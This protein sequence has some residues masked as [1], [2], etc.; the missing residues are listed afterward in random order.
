MPG[1][2]N[3]NVI[4]SIRSGGGGGAMGRAI[5]GNLNSVF[6]AEKKLD[7]NTLNQIFGNISGSSNIKNII[8]QNQNMRQS[9]MGAG[10]NVEK[11]QDMKKLNE[12][13]TKLDKKVQPGIQVVQ[14][15]RVDDKYKYKDMLSE[16]V[17]GKVVSDIQLIQ[18][19]PDKQQAI[20]VRSDSGDGVK[21]DVGGV[22]GGSRQQEL[23]QER[24]KLLK[25][26][27]EY[28]HLEVDNTKYIILAI[29]IVV[30]IMMFLLLK[31]V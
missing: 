27:E 6:G 12:I 13:F 10:S 24:K 8:S 9:I 20:S 5:G 15:P 17:G 29:V 25:S 26:V 19:L 28:S 22:G 4:Q 14:Q 16:I 7:R 2:I 23:I 11:E 21:S 31:N 18:P 1:G 3:S 30:V